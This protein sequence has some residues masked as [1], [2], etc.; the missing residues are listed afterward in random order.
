MLE[1]IQRQRTKGW[2]LPAGA[3]N[4]GR[5]TLLAQT[6]EPSTDSNRARSKR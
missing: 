5:S 1:R 2:R 4:V 3:V 6:T